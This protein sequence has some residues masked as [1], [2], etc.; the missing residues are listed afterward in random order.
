MGEDKKRS[1]MAVV[2]KWYR[3]MRQFINTWSLLYIVMGKACPSTPVSCD[4]VSSG[5][6]ISVKLGAH[7]HHVSV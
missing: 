7:I 4:T 1:E 3:N 5:R 6:E 2:Q